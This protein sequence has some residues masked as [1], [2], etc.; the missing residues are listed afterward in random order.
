MAACYPNLGR[1]LKGIIVADYFSHLRKLDQWIWG[2]GIVALSM[3]FVDGSY[4]LAILAL[5]IAFALSHLA[6]GIRRKDFSFAASMSEGM[7]EIMPRRMRS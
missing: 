4:G 2:I 1:V 3:F 5:F 7:K 6:G